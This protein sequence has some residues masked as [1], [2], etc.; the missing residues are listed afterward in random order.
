MEPSSSM[1]SAYSR[2]FCRE[3]GE[4]ISDEVEKD[5]EELRTWVSICIAGTSSK[6]N[7]VLKFAACTSSRVVCENHHKRQGHEPD[8]RTKKIKCSSF[9]GLLKLQALH[10]KGAVLSLETLCLGTQV[11]IAQN[12][13][14][15][16]CRMTVKNT[17]YLAYPS[18]HP[19]TLLPL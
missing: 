15:S 16:A 14:S 12:K 2:K 13:Q 4:K 3:L 8:D 17:V 6:E 5:R 19:R 18:C 11:T 1:Y 7:W 9:Q 10:Q